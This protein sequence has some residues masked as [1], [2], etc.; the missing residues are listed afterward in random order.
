VLLLHHHNATPATRAET[1]CFDAALAPINLAVQIEVDN[2]TPAP[3]ATVTY[4]VTV[5]NIGSQTV[6]EAVVDVQQPLGVK[7]ESHTASSGNFNLI[8]GEWLVGGLTPSQSAVL[9]ITTTVKPGTEG[10]TITNTATVY[11][12]VGEDDDPSDNTDSVD[13]SVITG[14]IAPPPTDGT[15]IPTIRKSGTTNGLGLPGD[16]IVWTITVT[17]TGTA[18]GIN[19]QVV[20]TVPAELRIDNAT[21]ERGTVAIDGQTVTFIIDQLDPG[22]SVQMQVFTTLLSAPSAG[23]LTN[24][25]FVVVPTGI[26]PGGT[27]ETTVAAT[28]A[29]VESVA[30][31]PATGYPPDES[32]RVAHPIP[33]WIIGMLALVLVVAG[34]ILLRQ[35]NG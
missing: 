26:G 22:Q 32:P 34:S 24:A 13:I 33:I 9:T 19:F 12:T 25:A 1:V 7:Y 20:D 18:P 6:P 16:Q 8:G 21:I 35:Q 5:S 23:M 29:E 11:P 14:G 28:S 3:G 4:T 31:L 15:F 30:E 10:R 2:P 17:N 27:V